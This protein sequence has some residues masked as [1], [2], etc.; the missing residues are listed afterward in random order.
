M[1]LVDICP[2]TNIDTGHIDFNNCV[3][4][5]VNPAGSSTESYVRFVVFAGW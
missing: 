2:I 1:S 4:K 5:S 3:S